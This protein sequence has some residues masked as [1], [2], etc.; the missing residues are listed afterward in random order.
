MAQS[1]E[2]LTDVA[3]NELFIWVWKSSQ[4]LNDIY[5]DRILSLSQVQLN[6]QFAAVNSK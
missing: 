4:I 6:E 5:I 3:L 1:L 2:F